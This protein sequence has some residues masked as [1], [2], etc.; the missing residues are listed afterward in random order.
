MKCGAQSFEGEIPYQMVLSESLPVFT[1]LQ[2]SSCVLSKV[3]SRL[4]EVSDLTVALNVSRYNQKRGGTRQ[5]GE[6]MELHSVTQ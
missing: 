4:G 5:N 3:N 1:H 2:T 6:H